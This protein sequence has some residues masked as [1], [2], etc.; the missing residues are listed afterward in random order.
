[1]RIVR[2]DAIGGP[3]NLHVVEVPVPEVGED[4]VLIQPALIGLIYGDTEIRRGTY[5]SKTIL[6]FFPGRE[7]AG[8]IVDVGKTLNPLG[9]ATE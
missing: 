8:T 9:S 3:E 2:L 1:M 7:V 5:F 4:D 6:P